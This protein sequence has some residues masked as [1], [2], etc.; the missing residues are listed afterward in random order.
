MEHGRIASLDV[1]VVGLGC[2]NFGWRLDADATARV[3][4]AALHAG[5][6]L[7]D[8]A[9]FYGEGRSEEY[10]GRALRGRRSQAII[11]T[12]FGYKT[13]PPNHRGQPANV[14]RAA[15]ASLKRLGM[16][17]IDLFQL[18]N[19]DPTT[20][21]ADTLGALD[22]LVRAGKV[23]EI[24][25]SNF[26]AEQLREAARLTRPGNA[27]FVS[28]QNEYSLI[29]RDAEADV[30]PECERSGVAFLPYFPLANGLLTGKYRRG[31][32]RPTNTRLRPDS[33]A[34]SDENLATVEELI[35]FAESKGRTMLE[36]AFGWLLTH[37]SVASVIAGAMTP[38]QV[39]GN[40]AAGEW[41]LSSEDRAAVNA[42]AV[43][44]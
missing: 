7:F 6:N 10:L 23:K 38:E 4:H 28:V 25:C 5:V 26:S 8:T 37:R 34:L 22:E 31:G 18:H 42:L 21:I 30:L 35:H 20:P 3:V 17:H 33:D 27:R 40:A 14:R 15:D 41:K 11:A 32:P 19:P 1:S 39:R 24:G 12:K 29:H 16:D 9:E 44:S 36:L 2:N 43:Y 13:A